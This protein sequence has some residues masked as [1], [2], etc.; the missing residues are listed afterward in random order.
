MTRQHEDRRQMARSERPGAL[1]RI[2]Q[3]R[4]RAV[5]RQRGVDAEALL[6][7]QPEHV[8]RARSSKKA[9]SSPS[10]S[11]STVM[12]AAMAWPPPL[13][14]RPRSTASRT[15]WPRSKPE[16][17]R[18][19]PVPTP[20]ALKAMAKAG[21]RACSFSR[22]AMQP[23]DAGMPFLAGGDDDRRPCPAGEFGVGFGAGLGQHL[24][25]HRLALLVEA[26]ER[27]GDLAGL[28][29]IVGGEQPAAERGVADAPAGIDARADQEGEM[30]GVD[31]LADARDARQRRNAGVL[32]LA[33]GEQSL[34][35]EGPVDAGQ[36]H[37]VA[38]R[39][40]AR[41]GRAATGDPAA[42]HPAA[43]REAPC[44]VCT[45]VRKT[46]PAAQRWPCPERSSSRLGLTTG[47][48]GGQRSADL[49]MVEHD[50]VGPAC[51]A[52]SIE[53][54]LLV[55]QSTVTISL[56]PR[57]TSSRIASGFGP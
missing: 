13:T 6:V 22:E 51:R 42:A 29:R 50:D 25:L 54:A 12:P 21:R 3:R 9:R 27:L 36:R 33:D 39:R 56:A 38:D 7:L 46:T 43:P 41:R 19:E 40:R 1:Q 30:E 37:H 16:T 26:V 28:D 48:A 57:E 34:D 18:P 47:N 55:P 53:G 5:G 52:A 15:S 23:D 4:R 11:R 10:L 8:G 17:E 14:I 45:S 35:H 2:E 44:A 49:V 20:L 31:R 24:L 32:L